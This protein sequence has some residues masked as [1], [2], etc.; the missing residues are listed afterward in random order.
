MFAHRIGNV[1]DWIEDCRTLSYADMRADGTQAGGD[2]HRR[3]VLGGSWGTQPR[4]LRSAERISYE[5]TA[6]DD[7]IGIRVAKT[8]SDRP[9]K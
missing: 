4:Q 6:I 8:L 2:C 5:P 7:S 1:A 9:Q 3:M